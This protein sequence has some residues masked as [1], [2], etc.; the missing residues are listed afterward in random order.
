MAVVLVFLCDFK[1]ILFRD[2]LFLSVCLNLINQLTLSLMVVVVL[3]LKKKMSSIKSYRPS[4]A[5]PTNRKNGHSKKENTK[6]L[7]LL[8]TVGVKFSTNASKTDLSLYFLF[9]NNPK[10]LC[11]FKMTEIVCIY[12]FLYVYFLLF[13]YI[14]HSQR[15]SKWDSFA[16]LYNLEQKL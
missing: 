6:V 13:F 7:L 12:C 16:K 11:W 4:K 3:T 10:N 5:K 8:R 9:S 15:V 14:V 1:N 2:R